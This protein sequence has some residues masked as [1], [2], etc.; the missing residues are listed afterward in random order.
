MAVAYVTH[1]FWYHRG[2]GFGTASFNIVKCK[3]KNGATCAQCNAEIYKVTSAVEQGTRYSQ[4]GW[5]NKF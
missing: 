3:V 5:K 4:D 2:S 1:A